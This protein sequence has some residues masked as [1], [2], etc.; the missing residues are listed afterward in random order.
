MNDI[1]FDFSSDSKGDSNSHSPTLAKYQIQD[2]DIYEE[3]IGDYLYKESY[4]YFKENGIL[5]EPFDAELDVDIYIN[6]D[7]ECDVFIDGDYYESTWKYS[8]EEYLDIDCPEVFDRVVL[9]GLSA[10]L[11]KYSNNEIIISEV[12][13]QIKGISFRHVFEKW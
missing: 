1:T 5:S 8:D 2:E 9:R 7:S 4:V 6:E 3:I 12:D 10:Y 11:V 13:P